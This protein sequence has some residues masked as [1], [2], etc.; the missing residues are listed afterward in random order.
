[1]SCNGCTSSHQEL[2]NTWNKKGSLQPSNYDPFKSM[3]WSTEHFCCGGN[4]D[5]NSTSWTRTANVTPGNHPTVYNQAVIRFTPAHKEK[6]CADC[7]S[8]YSRINQTW[9]HQKP[10]TSN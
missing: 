10:Y 6:F 2:M 5:N 7:H 1:M 3:H 4:Y 8:T 9:T